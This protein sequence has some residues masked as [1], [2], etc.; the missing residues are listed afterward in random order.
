MQEDEEGFRYP[1]VN[2]ELCIQCEACGK[3]CPVMHPVPVKDNA[4]PQTYAA[5]NEDWEVRRES[6]SGGVFHLLAEKILEAGGTVFGAGFDENW[7]VCH[8]SLI[9]I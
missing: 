6:S 4:I 9:H 7:E 5:I 1:V 3:V 2:D 8:L